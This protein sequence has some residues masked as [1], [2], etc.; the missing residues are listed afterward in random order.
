[1]TAWMRG[2]CPYAPS[3]SSVLVASGQGLRTSHEGP[4]GLH[5]R[6][7]GTGDAPAKQTL[8]SIGGRPT[9]EPLLI[10]QVLS[11]DSYQR[12]PL[13]RSKGGRIRV[14]TQLQL[15]LTAAFIAFAPGLGPPE[16]LS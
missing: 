15:R 9:L 8:A 13:A 7:A 5:L 6:R 2:L 11:G 16:R 10:K 3:T 4:R 12:S 14:I 1:M